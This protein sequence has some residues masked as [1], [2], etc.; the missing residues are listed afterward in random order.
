MVGRPNKII[1]I[2]GKIM[3]R[4]STCISLTENITDRNRGVLLARYLHLPVCIT[5]SL[6]YVLSPGS[7]G[8]TYFV[9]EMSKEI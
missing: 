9:E 7:F 6:C 4:A 8:S 3:D 5:F 1:V 2:T